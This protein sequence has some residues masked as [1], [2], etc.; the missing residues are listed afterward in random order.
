[1]KLD[2]ARLIIDFSP[3]ATPA[4]ALSVLVITERPQIISINS[5]R[6][7]LRDFIL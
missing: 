4:V 2:T 7:I 6:E 5:Q 1:M 3:D